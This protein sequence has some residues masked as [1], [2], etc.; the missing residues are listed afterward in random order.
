[1]AVIA[2]R[3]AGNSVLLRQFHCSVSHLVCNQRPYAI[4][5]IIYFQLVSNDVLSL[6]IAFSLTIAYR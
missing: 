5:R 4:I 3:T 1:M 6:V 2:N